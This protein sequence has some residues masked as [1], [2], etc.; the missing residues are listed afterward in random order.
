MLHEP[1]YLTIARALMLPDAPPAEV[2]GGVARLHP[3][4]S[5][6]GGNRDG[7]SLDLEGTADGTVRLAVFTDAQLEEPSDAVR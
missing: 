3:H 6:P 1:D 4:F 5:T 7:W 2:D